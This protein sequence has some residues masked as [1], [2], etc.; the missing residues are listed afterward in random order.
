MD[1]NL[2]DIWKLKK[3]GARDSERHKDLIKKAIK[4]NGKELI[5]EYNIIKSDGNK[6]IKVPIKFLERYKFKY[7]NK[8]DQTGV[9]QGVDVKPGDVFKRKT[10]KSQSGGEPGDEEGS[11]E[12]NAEVSIDELVDLLIEELNLPWLK[13]TATSEIE[14]ENEEFMGIEKVGIKP[15]LDM[16]KTIIANMKRNA[17]NGKAEIKNI[18]KDDFRY[19]VYDSEKDYHSNAAVYLMM[20]RS[21]SMTKDKTDIAKSFYF[22][23]VQF[24]KRKYKNLDIVFIAHDSVAFICDEDDFFKISSNGGTKCS[25]AFKLAYEHMVNNHPAEQWNNYVFEMSDGDNYGDDNLIVLDYVN[26]MLPLVR[27]MGYAE[28]LI[29]DAKDMPWYSESKMLSTLLKEK[30]NRTRFISMQITK[31]E[32]LFTALKRFFNIDGISRK[33]I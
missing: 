20:D 3:R 25:S 10:D 31:K 30:V 5:T 8:N 7:D 24:L 23:M 2:S 19:K 6:K 21:G 28:I 16:K 1:S 33:R 18:V 4:E 26:K 14:V 15:N 9:G 27:A 17:A 32:E 11:R 29:A 12:Y 13:P 22:W